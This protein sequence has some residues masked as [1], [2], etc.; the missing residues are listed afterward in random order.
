MPRG[1]LLA[2]GNKDN[3]LRVLGNSVPRPR[4]L[5]LYGDVLARYLVDPRSRDKW[6]STTFT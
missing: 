3:P 5:A 4:L 2:G 6:T 1:A